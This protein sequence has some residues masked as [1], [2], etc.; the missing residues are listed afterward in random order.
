MQVL[1]EMGER[2][3]RTDA[4]CFGDADTIVVTVSGQQDRPLCRWLWRRSIS[5][6]QPYHRLPP[7]MLSLRLLQSASL[8]K[9]VT[10]ACMA[11]RN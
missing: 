3:H 2:D 6:D 8:R 11:F 1:R 7:A 5:H 4:S 9:I 10:R